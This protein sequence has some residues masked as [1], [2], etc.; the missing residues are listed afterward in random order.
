MQVMQHVFRKF[1]IV[2]LGTS[3]FGYPLITI[4]GLEGSQ[5]R[6]VHKSTY[7][8]CVAAATQSSPQSVHSERQRWCGCYAK[9]VVDNVTSHDIKSFSAG[10]GPTPR[11]RKVA[12]DAIAYCKRKLY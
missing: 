12:A 6:S 10:S 5:R 4:A 11:M 3:L 2:V 1:C 8:S 7:K 9:Q